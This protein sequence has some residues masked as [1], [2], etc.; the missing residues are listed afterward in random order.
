MNNKPFS[1]YILSL[2]KLKKRFENLINQVEELSAKNRELMNYKSTVSQR[3]EARERVLQ[4]ISKDYE[5][6]KKQNADRDISS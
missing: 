2:D 3:E 4:S 5:E 6:L 1:N